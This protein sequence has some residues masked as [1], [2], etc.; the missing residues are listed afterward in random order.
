VK[1]GVGGTWRTI[2]KEAYAD[3]AIVAS[4]C[5]QYAV[6]HFYPGLTGK[7]GPDSRLERLLESLGIPIVIHKVPPQENPQE[8]KTHHGWLS[9]LT[10][11]LS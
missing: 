11:I 7:T 10:P 2:E 4:G 8:Q 9:W 3:A 1:A 6:W 5:A